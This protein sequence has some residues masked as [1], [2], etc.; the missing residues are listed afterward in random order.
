MSLEKIDVSVC[1]LT[2]FHEKYISEAIESVLSQ[3]THF[4]FELVISDDC[5]KDNT[6]SIIKEYENKYP[7]IIRVKI[8]ETNIGI[9]KNIYQARCMCRGRYIVLLSGDDYWIDDK[10]IEKETSFLDSHSEY[11]SVFNCVELRIDDSKNAYE[12]RPHKRF[13]NK[14]YSIRDFEKGKILASHGFMMRNEF[15]NEEGREYFH[16]AQEISAYVDDAVD[17]VL[18][19]KKG[20]VFVLNEIT[21]AHRVIRKELNKN[22]YNSRY[23]RIEKFKHQIELYNELY[24]CFGN[25]IDFSWW[26]ADSYSVGVLGM[27]ASRDF[28][29]Y[30]E[31][32]KTIPSEYR[33]LTTKS[34][35]VRL[36][37]NIFRHIVSRIKNR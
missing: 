21:D 19:L 20:P 18:I 37:P 6:V 3:K 7:D 4:R 11:F 33:R 10:K 24:N 2:Y 12:I 36:V 17:N 35:Y 16:K 32:F 25:E 8:N 9:P 31:I 5:S 28:S 15:L 29:G 30:K 13:R 27:V 34:I 23:T 1:M 26:F 14:E 22:N